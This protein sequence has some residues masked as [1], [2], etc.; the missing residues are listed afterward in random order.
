MKELAIK[1]KEKGVKSQGCFEYKNKISLADFKQL[2]LIFSDFEKYG[3][4]IEKAFRK[5]IEDKESNKFPF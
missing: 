4:N 1:I 3:A 2:A 5:F